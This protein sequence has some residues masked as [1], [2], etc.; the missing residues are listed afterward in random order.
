MDVSGTV[1]VVA[2]ATSFA[3]ADTLLLP[4]PLLMP[5]LLLS[6]LPVLVLTLLPFFLPLLIYCFCCC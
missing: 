4:L 2:A 6:R 5:L 3:T 1:A